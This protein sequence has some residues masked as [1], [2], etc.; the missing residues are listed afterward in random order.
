ML[1][2]LVN[3]NSFFLLDFERFN[4]KLRINATVTLEN[5]LSYIKT[6]VLPLINDYESICKKLSLHP[7]LNQYKFD[8]NNIKTL[9]QLEQIKQEFALFKEE[10]KQAE[11]QLYKQALDNLI[12]DKLIVKNAINSEIWVINE[13]LI[14]NKDL[15]K[16]TMDEVQLYPSKMITIYNQ[17]TLNFLW[18][19]GKILQTSYNLRT[20]LENDFK[21]KTISAGGGPFMLQGKLTEDSELQ[22]IKKYIL[23]IYF[24]IIY[25]KL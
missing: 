19:I 8:F 21:N 6:K 13:N 18:I 22:I 20:I 12:I 24:F 1:N 17:A 4:D 15:I 3:L 25:H 9:S 2:Q 23:K 7:I 16:L 14:N 10:A 11:K 5:Y